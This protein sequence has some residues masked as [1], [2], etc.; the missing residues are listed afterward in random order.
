MVSGKA[1]VEASDIPIERP[2]RS[3]E[4]GMANAQRLVAEIVRKHVLGNELVRNTA[5][6]LTVTLARPKK[7]A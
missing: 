5:D 6:G 2:G 1:E 4:P 7:V 3:G